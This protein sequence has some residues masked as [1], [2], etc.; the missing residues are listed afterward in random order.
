MS[1][2]LFYMDKRKSKIKNGVYNKRPF[3]NIL[4]LTEG[5]GRFY[6]FRLSFL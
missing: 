6:F 5:K 3:N 2:A 4:F 1:F